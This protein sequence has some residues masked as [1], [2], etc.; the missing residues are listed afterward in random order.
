[1]YLCRKSRGCFF[2]IPP[3][4]PS[5]PGAIFS[6]GNGVFNPP[7]SLSGRVCRS[8]IGEIFY[9]SAGGIFVIALELSFV[10]SETERS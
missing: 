9:Q 5:G 1:M 3:V 7:S 8:I 10:F 2:E 4:S 6:W